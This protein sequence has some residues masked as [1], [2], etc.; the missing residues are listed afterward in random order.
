MSVLATYD[1]TNNF[2]HRAPAC[3]STRNTAIGSMY[4]QSSRV[5]LFGALRSYSS[6]MTW[7]DRIHQTLHRTEEGKA[8]GVAMDEIFAADPAQ[9]AGR[10][11]A[12]QRRLRQRAMGRGD[13][14]TGLIKQA[15]PPAI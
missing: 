7:G 2:G 13:V 9:F 11:E 15:R 5:V 4:A 8:G 14:V 6:V 3:V 12:G 10:K 1:A